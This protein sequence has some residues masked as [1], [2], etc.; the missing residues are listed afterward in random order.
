M[1]FV[2]GK[3]VRI[4]LSLAAAAGAGYGMVACKTRTDAQSAVKGYGGPT[5]F[6]DRCGKAIDAVDPELYTRSPR[7]TI[8]DQEVE[9]CIKIDMDAYAQSQVYQD[10]V[11]DFQRAGG[12]NRGPEAGRSKYAPSGGRY[13][14]DGPYVSSGK[15]DAY[16]GDGR[17]WV[18]YLTLTHLYNASE[19]KDN[20]R[21]YVA[22]L[23]KLINS[24]SSEPQIVRTPTIDPAG[25]I[26]RINLYDYGWTPAMWDLVFS[27]DGVQF[28][29][30][31]RDGRGK[32]IDKFEDVPPYI[33][34]RVYDRA[35][36]GV[37]GRGDWF[38]AKASIPPLYHELLK[39]PGLDHI[40][41]T[42]L[43]LEAALFGYPEQLEANIMTNRVLRAGFNQSGVS[44]NNRM[45]ERHQI[46]TGYYW[47]SYDFDRSSQTRSF[48]VNPFGPCFRVANP[49]S[50]NGNKAI[51]SKCDD[52][53]K[54]NPAFD[55][56]DPLVPQLVPDDAKFAAQR[57][58]QQAGGEAIWSLP[59]K[60]QGYLLVKGDGDRLSIGPANIVANNGDKQ[61]RAEII[62]GL[63]CMN[64]HFD[65]MIRGKPDQL[66]DIMMNIKDDKNLKW[67]ASV[68]PRDIEAF[69]ET[70]TA[71]G[72]LDAAIEKD[73]ND[74][75]KAEIAAMGTDVERGNSALE[76][77]NF[78]NNRYDQDV[79]LASAAAEL[80]VSADQLRTAIQDGD[81]QGNEALKNLALKLQR[82]ADATI[83]RKDFE[84]AFE[85]FQ[86]FVTVNANIY[87]GRR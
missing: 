47:K 20:I 21:R 48:M 55:G 68:D 12:Y 74:Y 25:T 31:D 80:G 34:Q 65:G 69:A 77:V 10:D 15:S 19:G 6:T 16:N 73:I 67:V 4:M 87:T 62:N 40:T 64:C 11:R 44:A 81:F 56:K 38:V 58:F 61:R 41:D 63:S 82:A 7:P 24:L 35:L 70:V 29:V 37:Y 32:P 86:R 39:P 9:A 46:T 36:E 84:L 1:R 45:I 26:V 51:F 30:P 18:R 71:K 54:T 33:Y 60:L 28:K 42:D 49:V 57:V 85:A 23:S 59:N 83:Q 66:H 3:G 14:S 27:K 17:P 50:P 22:G 2:N 75:K 79:D 43:E 72:A 52:L 13:N 78:L 5:T 53:L 76:P 8:S